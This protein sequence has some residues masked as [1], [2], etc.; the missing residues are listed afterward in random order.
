M[1]VKIHVIGRLGADA[2]IKET[3]QGKKFS[4]FHLAVDDFVQ[5]KRSTVWFAVADFSEAAERRAEFLKK[6]TLIEVSGVESCR[7]YLDRSNLPQIARDIR[8]TYIDFVSL[9][10]KQEKDAE[11]TESTASTPITVQPVV[12]EKKV[13]PEVTHQPQQI[14]A[15]AAS[16]DDTFVDDLPF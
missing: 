9:G 8:A 7:A 5:G 16:T 10:G 1:S 13:T 12:P 15:T 14:V 11:S 6:G 2:E 3:K 4:T